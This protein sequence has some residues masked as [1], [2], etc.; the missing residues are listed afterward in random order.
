M[1]MEDGSKATDPHVALWVGL[2]ESGDQCQI[3]LHELIPVVG[4][5]AW[6]GVVQSQMDDDFVPCE[7]Q[8]RL[9]FLRLV[10]RTMAMPKQCCSTS[11][12]IPHFVALT[13]QL[14]KLS[15]IA[16]RLIL[17][18]KVAEKIGANQGVVAR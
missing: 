13:Q 5:V 18:R 4:P 8:G 7:L 15:W 10:I 1:A 3:V 2:P 14:L 6:I 17:L 12:E 9:V 11:P 16:L